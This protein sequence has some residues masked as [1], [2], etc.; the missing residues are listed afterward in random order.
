MTA[1][2]QD[3][4]KIAMAVAV[5]VA[6]FSASS[7]S[8]AHADDSDAEPVPEFSLTGEE[9]TGGANPGDAV[10]LSGG[11]Q[12]LDRFT[13]HTLYYRIPRSM[14]NSTVHVGVS[15][16][17]PSG[18]GASVSVSL[19]TW[20]SDGCESSSIPAF[21]TTGQLSGTH[22]TVG[23]TPEA[24][25]EDPCVAAQELVLSVR[26][27]TSGE[28][29]E[30]AGQPFEILVY[31]E[32]E[33]ANLNEFSD[34][35]PDY[36]DIEWTDMSRDMASELE[37]TPGT[38]YQ[39]SAELTPG[40]TYNLQIR[41][42]EV[43]VFRVP[44]EWGEYL[45][46]EAFFPEPGDELSDNLSGME[47]VALAIRS[48]LHTGVV[49][50]SV[51]PSPL[52]SSQLRVRSHPIAWYNRLDWWDN[53]AISLAGDFYLVLIADEHQDGRDFPLGYRLT[54]DTFS[55]EE[56]EPQAPQY[57]APH[58]DAA[59]DFHGAEEE[60]EASA[61]G[62][63]GLGSNPALVIALGAFGLVMIIAGSLILVRVAR[64]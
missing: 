3:R 55:Y 40:N 41:P 39:Q 47:Q 48:P 49:A 34:L 10:E 52:S 19:D 44:L 7:I 11:N 62:L 64:S 16:Y 37:V 43:Q 53:P 58:E 17:R 8:P 45:Q 25:D 4:P 63:R 61:P 33:P 15:T 29:S 60:A 21:T 54:L 12:Y 57:P 36:D 46:A 31:E 30:T 2:G 18:E 51:Y 38:S 22:L 23:P 20:E 50:E 24:D 35:E 56:G 14:E 13:D 1:S 27:D 9:I 32:P 26:A 42:G 28:D 6:L 5:L 59:P